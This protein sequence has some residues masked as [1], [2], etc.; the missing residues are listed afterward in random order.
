MTYPSLVFHYSFLTIPIA[1]RSTHCHDS[2]NMTAL[3]HPSSSPHD[4]I[5]MMSCHYAPHSRRVDP[6]NL[7]GD[8]RH[9]EGYRF[10]GWS[11]GRPDSGL[12]DLLTPGGLWAG[13]CRVGSLRATMREGCYGMRNSGLRHVLPNSCKDSCRWNTLPRDTAHR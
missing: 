11:Y 6:A 10:Q 12:S 9:H 5:D 3:P 2:C 7:P 13:C 8:P 1:T 4:M